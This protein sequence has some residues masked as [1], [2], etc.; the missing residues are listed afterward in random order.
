MNLIKKLKNKKYK[1][2]IT[3]TKSRPEFIIITLI[4]TILISLDTEYVD[5]IYSITIGFIIFYIDFK[6][7]VE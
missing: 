3:I 2:A 5:K 7:T 6:I 1:F 4:P